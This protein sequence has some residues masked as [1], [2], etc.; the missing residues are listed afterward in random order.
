MGQRPDALTELMQARPPP[1]VMHD[2]AAQVGLLR[3]REL[4]ASGHRQA[5]AGRA[6]VRFTSSLPSDAA[7]CSQ[8]PRLCH[9]CRQSVSWTGRLSTDTCLCSQTF[10]ADAGKDAAE[11]AYDRPSPK[12]LSFMSKHY[13]GP[14][15][16]VA[17]YFREAPA[18]PKCRTAFS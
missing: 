1:A 9:W 17:P 5:P 12:L 3:T 2:H 6:H 15:L 10:L 11:L 7:S 16:D 14:T 13:G 18:N 8:L 4:P